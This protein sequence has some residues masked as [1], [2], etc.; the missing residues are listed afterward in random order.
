FVHRFGPAHYAFD[1]A[2]VRL[3]R[4]TSKSAF[5]AAAQAIARRLPET[6]G[7]L[8]IADEA[9]QAGQV[10]HAIRPQAVALGLFALLTA[11]AALFAI[12]QLFARQVF[13]VSDDNGTLRALGMSRRQLMVTALAQVG[14]T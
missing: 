9:D 11:L 5:S 14:G 10:N 12:G 3:A 7:N 13:L 2:E 1:G 6:G 8:Q 4:G